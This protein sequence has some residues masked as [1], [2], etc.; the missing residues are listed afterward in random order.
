MAA[1]LASA[2]AAN[3]DQADL[4]RTAIDLMARATSSSEVIAVNMLLVPVVILGFI[5]VALFMF[6]TTSAANSNTARS[7]EDNYLSTD[8]LTGGLCYLMVITGDEE[9][10]SCVQKHA[11]Y[12]P[13]QA[14]K[15]ALFGDM[16]LTAYNALDGLPVDDMQAAAKSAIAD[17]REHSLNN[18]DCDI[19]S[20]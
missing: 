20:W 12:K 13:D 18:G 11:C 6:M 17:A 7:A 19:Y 5:L 15:L 16:V 1:C 9:K 14:L 2:Q 3:A 4:I 8:N 10:L